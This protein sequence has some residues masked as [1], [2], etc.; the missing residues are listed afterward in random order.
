MKSIH[1][2]I[3]AMKVLTLTI[4]FITYILKFFKQGKKRNETIQ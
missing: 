1:K 2:Y 3:T 4:I